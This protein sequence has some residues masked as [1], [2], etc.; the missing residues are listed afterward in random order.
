MNRGK[1]GIEEM[2]AAQGWWVSTTAGWSMFPMLRDRRDSI[3]LYPADRPI[4]RYDVVLYR[5]GDSYILH[6]V[7]KIYPDHFL[8][9]GDNCFFMENVP[10]GQILA[11]LGE[12]YRGDKRID[13]QGLPYKIYVRI[14]R[15]LYPVRFMIHKGRVRL[16]C[17]RKKN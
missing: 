9:R 16:C 15:W 7:L 3:V 11:V 5:S 17:M 1:N 4:R 12:F 10:R 6:R 14:W 8:I 13:M 2:L